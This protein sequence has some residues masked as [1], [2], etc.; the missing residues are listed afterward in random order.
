MGGSA[1]T[2]RIDR[3]HSDRARSASK[4][5]GRLTHAL[6]SH[7]HLSAFASFTLPGRQGGA[8]LKCARRTSAF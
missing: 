4:E 1:S 2:A 8:A 7:D 6:A 3:A 5:A